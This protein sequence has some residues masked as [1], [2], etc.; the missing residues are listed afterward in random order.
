M[1]YIDLSESWGINLILRSKLRDQN[2]YFINLNNSRW[3]IYSTYIGCV[4]LLCFSTLPSPLLRSL[5]SLQH[6]QPVLAQWRARG[7]HYWAR[8]WIPV[9]WLWLDV[10]PGLAAASVHDHRQAVRVR[11]GSPR[12]RPPTPIHPSH[13]GLASPGRVKPRSPPVKSSLSQQI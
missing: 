8:P 9:G 12:A 11:R 3:G 2:T 13:P 6:A 1:D 10:R 5:S 4:V 7:G